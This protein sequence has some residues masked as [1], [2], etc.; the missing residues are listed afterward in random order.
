MLCQ[1]NSKV[2]WSLNQK[3]DQSENLCS[4]TLNMID[5]IEKQ[6]NNGLDNGV[7]M[8]KMDVTKV[9]SMMH[10]LKQENV[11]LRKEI[12][13]LK[14]NMVINSGDLADQ[15][16]AK[17]SNQMMQQIHLKFDGATNYLVAHIEASSDRMLK[18]Y[19]NTIQEAM[20]H[21]GSYTPQ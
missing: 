15:V 19:D 21:M 1:E 6:Q 18:H 12:A 7:G 2:M 17:V 10:D 20:E 3:C 4:H 8:A 16:V 9:L 13:S 14:R 11:E 5:K